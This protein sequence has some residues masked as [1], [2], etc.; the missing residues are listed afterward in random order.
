MPIRVGYASISHTQSAGVGAACFLPLVKSACYTIAHRNLM[1]SM[2]KQHAAR[3][4][5]VR[6]GH[7]VTES[8]EVG[9]AAAT[10]HGAASAH[11]SRWCSCGCGRSGA[12]G[13]VGR[14]TTGLYRLSTSAHSSRRGWPSWALGEGQASVARRTRLGLGGTT[15]RHY[16][17]RFQGARQGFPSPPPRPSPSTTSTHAPLAMGRSLTPPIGEALCWG[18]RCSTHS[19]AV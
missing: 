18:C 15:C 14:G 6:G 3:R 5:P 4:G 11:T 8:W 19:A 1:V 7:N 16:S 9:V 13:E 10:Q 2:S 17:K 12:G